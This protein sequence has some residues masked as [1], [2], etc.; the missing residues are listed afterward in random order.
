MS[1]SSP[2]SDFT[3]DLS[4]PLNDDISVLSGITSV[5]NKRE[6]MGGCIITMFPP[7]TDIKWLRPNTYFSD[8]SLIKVWCGQ[9]EHTQEDNLHCHIYVEFTKQTR[10]EL[11]R[12]SISNVLEKGC[13]IKRQ[14]RLSTKSRACAVNYV[15]KPEG[16][17]AG[18]EAYIWEHCKHPIK[19]DASL[20]GQRKNN[21]S[22]SKEAKEKLIIDYIES[23]P[24]HWT[25][26]Q[27]LHEST[28]SKYLLAS[29][30]WGA[31]YHSTRHASAARRTIDNVI[32]LY[33]AG[34]TG[35]TTL[36]HKWGAVENE[37]FYERYYR[38][39]PDDG[40]FWGGGKTAYKGQ[41]VIHMEEFCGQEQLNRVKELCD[42]GKQGPSVNI[43]NSGTTLN[44][45]TIIFTSNYHPAAWYRNKWAEEAKQFHPFWRRITQ[46]WFF[47]SHRPDGTLNVPDENTPPHY[48]DQTDEWVALAGDYNA[49]VTHASHHWPLSNVG[50]KSDTFHDPNM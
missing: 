6:K 34:G 47:P 4:D 13:N 14:K 17:F 40:A 2:I 5:V 49:C 38:R 24:K 12:T 25:W 43:K 1:Q 18:T 19:F 22:Q 35:K 46:V 11:I 39:N 15:L 48:I 31:K 44:H 20:W 23:K 50:S 10:F 16:R 37:D 26:E 21:T 28:E 45:D 32:I 3:L 30:S 29:C 7:D 33:G 41:R 9:F 8:S 36:A 27:I 42:I